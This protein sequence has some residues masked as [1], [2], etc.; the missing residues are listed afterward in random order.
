MYDVNI[1]IFFFLFL[2]ERQS[3]LKLIVEE[4]KIFFANE[5]S[6]ITNLFFKALKL[7]IFYYNNNFLSIFQKIIIFSNL[8]LGV[9]VYCFDI[10]NDMCNAL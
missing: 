5:F 2:I 3:N 6:K 8:I 1:S 10:C 7:S 9:Y 4:K